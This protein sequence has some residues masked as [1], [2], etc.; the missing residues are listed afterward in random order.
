MT[1]S[2]DRDVFRC[3]DAED[4]VLIVKD[5]TVGDARLIRIRREFEHGSTLPAA[6]VRNLRD[7]L[8]QWLGDDE[9]RGNADRQALNHLH[10]LRQRDAS[11]SEASYLT[12]ERDRLLDKVA[13]LTVECDRMREG[14]AAANEGVNERLDQAF[15][16]GYG[17]CYMASKRTMAGYPGFVRMAEYEAEAHA[18]LAEWHK[19]DAPSED[20]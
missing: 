10:S 14:W 7:A 19:A 5:E 13:H 1:G 8:T 16:D 2:H 11:R 6:K 9:L 17:A 4:D 12:A 20:E 15:I 3:I 18:A